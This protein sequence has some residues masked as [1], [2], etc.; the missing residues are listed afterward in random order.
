MHSESKL[1]AIS[2]H[3]V[4]ITSNTFPKNF[5]IFRTQIKCNKS[6][7]GLVRQEGSKTFNSFLTKSSNCKTDKTCTFPEA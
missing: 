4:T 1:P 3:K 5:Q 7:K 6:A 2:E